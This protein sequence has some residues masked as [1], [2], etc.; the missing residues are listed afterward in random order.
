MVRVSTLADKLT[1]VKAEAIIDTLAER[2][3]HP[4]LGTPEVEASGWQN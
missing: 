1:K 3:A 4:D 2:L